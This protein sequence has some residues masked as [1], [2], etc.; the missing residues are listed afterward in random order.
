MSQKAWSVGC[1]T[2]WWILD[3]KWKMPHKAEF[4]SETLTR[5]A[6]QQ[7]LLL[8]YLVGAACSRWKIGGSS[9]KGVD[10]NPPYFS[11]VKLSTPLTWLIY[12]A[13]NTLNETLLPFCFYFSSIFQSI[14][15]EESEK[16]PKWRGNSKLKVGDLSQK[17]GELHSVL[18]PD[19]G[20]IEATAARHEAD[21]RCEAKTWKYF[22]GL[23]HVVYE[24]KARHVKEQLIVYEL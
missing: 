1:S 13:I 2:G 12:W 15:L 7:W 17:G 23:G 4:P 5:P 9:F 11:P 21:A 18:I 3:A 22:W 20:G 6:G 16:T 10:Q 14:L 8:L 19:L 24:A